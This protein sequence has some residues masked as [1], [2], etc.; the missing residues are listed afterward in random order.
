MSEQSQKLPKSEIL[1]SKVLIQELFSKDSSSCYLYP[2][3]IVYCLKTAQEA[4]GYPQV[5]FSVSKKHFKR[6][7]QRNLLRR[8]IKEAYRLQ[9]SQLLPPEGA[10]F[11]HLAILFI[12]KEILE[13]SVISEKM[14]K[15]FGILQNKCAN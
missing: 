14:R 5:L 8:R 3:K 10:A 4:P 1:R 13:F 12:A 7:H 6:A 15:I 9:K 11:S 2:F